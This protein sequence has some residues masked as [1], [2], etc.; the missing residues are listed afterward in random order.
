MNLPNPIPGVDP[1]PDYANNISSCFTF[2]DQH[3]H[4]PGSGQQI[5]PAGINI[6]A[7][8]PMNGNSLT[9]IG[10]LNFAPYGSPLAGVAPNLG[11]LYVSGNELYYNDESGNVL[12]MTLNGALNVTSSGISSGTASASF[13]AGVLVVKSTSTS[14]ANVLGQ[15]F[16][17]TNSGNLTNQL[18]LAAPTLTTSYQL[19]L[20]T[21]PSVKS[22][23]TLD[24]SGNFGTVARPYPIVVGVNGDYTTINA[25]I[26]AASSGQSIFIQPGTYTENIDLTINLYITG[27]GRGT[28]LNG[29]LTMDTG[30]DYSL[31]TNLRVNSG[32]TINAGVTSAQVLNFWS[33]PN[34]TV[35]DNGTGSFLQG[36]QE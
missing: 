8:L 26:S 10:T 33:A 28:V 25:A 9:T 36:I 12:K 18:T 5:N 32:I 20:P 35:T 11:C 17:F 1:G 30:S 27:S 21:I 4:A 6:N 14:G 29:S 7:N 19:T 3:N 22:N 16:V 24:T 23:V 13:V 31:V 2:L 15:S 34:Q